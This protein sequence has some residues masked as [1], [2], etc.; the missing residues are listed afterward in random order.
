MP[1]IIICVFDILPIHF[2]REVRFL[3]LSR[4]NLRAC[5]FG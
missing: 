2:L 3:Y 5:L 1:A 4:W